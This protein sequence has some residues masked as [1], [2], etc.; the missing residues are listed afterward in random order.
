MNTLFSRPRNDPYFDSYNPAWSNQSNISRQAHAP[1]NY[2]LQFHELYHQA[3]PQF[4]DQSYS[5]QYQAT[6]QQKYQ[7]EPPLPMSSDFQDQMLKF[8]R[9][10]D[11]IMDSHNQM[12]NPHS[13]SIDKIEVH[14]EEPTPFYWPPQ[15]QYQDDPSLLS[16][17]NFKMLNLMRKIE[18]TNQIMKSQHEQCTPQLFAEIEAKMDVYVEQ[19]INHLNR[20]EEEEL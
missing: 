1:E 3:Y 13:E 6:P 10:M 7:A 12:V 19:I 14:E 11:Q 4:N 8:M 9:K 17:S 18:E 15:Q 5:T 20:E 2:A 16:D